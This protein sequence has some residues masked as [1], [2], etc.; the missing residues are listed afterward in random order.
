MSL[1]VKS[2]ATVRKSLSLVIIQAERPEFIAKSAGT[3]RQGNWNGTQPVAK[4]SALPTAKS[5]ARQQVDPGPGSLEA[6]FSEAVSHG[7]IFWSCKFR[8][9]GC[10]AAH[11]TDSKLM[12][13]TK[14]QQ[15]HAGQCDS[16][17]IFSNRFMYVLDIQSKVSLPNMYVSTASLGAERSRLS[18]KLIRTGFWE[19]SP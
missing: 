10:C 16:M 5:M 19:C 11:T 9:P 14:V 2:W 13:T 12:R 18:S 4:R 1:C 3:W 15:T 8:S 17:L 6:W 7:V